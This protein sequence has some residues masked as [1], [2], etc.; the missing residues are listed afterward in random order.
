M[1][2]PDVSWKAFPTC[3]QRYT[4]DRYLQG[5]AYNT[6]SCLIDQRVKRSPE[7]AL[8]FRIAASIQHPRLQNAHAE[9]I[10]GIYSLSDEQS[11]PANE[12]CRLFAIRA[13]R[14]NRGKV[15]RTVSTFRKA[16]RGERVF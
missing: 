3:S 7:V 11:I 16:V 12:L 9:S 6:R 10:C 4:R 5:D 2:Q 8:K 1:R 15:S 14:N 13:L